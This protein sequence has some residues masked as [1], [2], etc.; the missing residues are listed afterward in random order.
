M[1]TTIS[2]TRQVQE[3]IT[4]FGTK[5][6]TYNDILARILNRAKERQIQEILMDEKGTVTVK[7]ALAEAKK[8]W[9]R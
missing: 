9:Q 7:E 4:E 1:N 2:I 6:E 5:G 3:Q 8:R